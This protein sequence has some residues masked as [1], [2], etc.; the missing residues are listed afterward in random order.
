MSLVT[1]AIGFI[2]VSLVVINGL[3][4]GG[5]WDAVGAF[6]TDAEKE[7]ARNDI[8][9]GTG[10]LMYTP[11]TDFNVTGFDGTNLC[12]IDVPAPSWSNVFIAGLVALSL[13]M[14]LRITTG[15]KWKF[16][17][18]IYIF[19][20]AWIGI[21]ILGFILMQMSGPDCTAW[22]VEAVDQT[23]GFY[24]VAAAGG[25]FW[26]IKILWGLRK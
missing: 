15:I 5:V 10:Y 18:S 23:S 21:K 14:I 25:T 3:L 11:V 19:I 16:I 17:Y 13:I 8:M 1:Q 2:F 6:A 20:A 22:A 4:G 7:E 26:G 9:C 12:T 24:E